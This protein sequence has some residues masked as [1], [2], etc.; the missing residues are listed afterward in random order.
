[1]KKHVKKYFV[2]WQ[3][4][5]LAHNK[6][7]TIANHLKECAECRNYFDKMNELLLIP[8]KQILQVLQKDPYLPT[9]IKANLESNKKRNQNLRGLKFIRF[10]FN[11][12]LLIIAVSIGIYLGSN[13]SNQDSEYEEVDL[14]ATYYQAFSQQN[15]ADSYKEIIESEQEE[16]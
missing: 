15:I 2:D 1:M 4:G 6:M 7:N 5:K 11:S 9:K 13:L 12:F 3:D 8:D 14:A 10:A 16:Q